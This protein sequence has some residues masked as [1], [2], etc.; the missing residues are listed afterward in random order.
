MDTAPAEPREWIGLRCTG[1][2]SHAS[3][4]AHALVRAVSRLVS[5][6]AVSRGGVEKSLD[7]ARTSACATSVVRV[8]LSLR[9]REQCAQ[10]VH[11]PARPLQ[12]SL[13]KL[14]V[15]QDLAIDLL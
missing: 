2:R 15:S 5:T 7:A 14:A 9:R 10:R 1:I 3:R 11:S 12:K 13:G 6:P 4:V 8:G